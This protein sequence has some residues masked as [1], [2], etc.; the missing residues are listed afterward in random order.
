MI[1][2][3]YKMGIMA[4][5]MV[6]ACSFMYCFHVFLGA[7]S[8]VS[9]VFYVPIVLACIWWKRKGLIVAVA[10]SAFLTISHI[11]LRPDVATADDYFRAAMF[12][13]IGFIVAALSEHIAKDQDLLRAANQQLTASEQQLRASNQQLQASEQQLRAANQ[14]LDASNQQLRASEEEL[15]KVNH[16][17]EDRVKEL[18]CL[19]GL[20]QLI[21]RPGT[22]VEEILQ[23]LAELIPTAWEYSEIT[24]ARIILENRRFETANFRKTAWLQSAHIKVHGKKAGTIEVCYLQERPPMD[25]GPFLKEERELLDLLAKRLG[26]TVERIRDEEE[27][28]AAHQQ[29]IASE[30]QLK[31][32]N[33]QL[34]ANEQQLQAANQQLQAT[35][36]QLKAANQQLEADIAER[37]RMETAL[38]E[39]EQLFRLIVE[40]AFDGINICEFDPDTNKRR[41]VSCNDH[42]VKMSG[43]TREQLVNAENLN[44]LVVQHPSKAAMTTPGDWI[45]DGTSS[46]GMTSWKR[47]DGKE[48]IYEWS[49]ISVKKG[50]KFQIIG[51][52]RDI[53][54]RKKT[55]ERLRDYRRRLRELASELV[56]AE[57]HLRRRI[58]RDLHDDVGQELLSVKMRLAELRK[59]RASA[60]R[61]AA[62]EGILKSV[63]RTIQNTRSLLFDLSPPVLY[64]LG[65]EPAVEWLTEKLQA[66]HGI[67]TVFEDDGQAKPLTDD[68]RIGLFR[69]LRELLVNIVKHAQAKNVKVSARRDGPNIRVEVQDDGVGFDVEKTQVPGD[70][71]NGFG[72]FDI[73]ERLHHFDG[74]F[75]IESKPGQG[76]RVTLLAPLK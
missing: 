57:E 19:Y 30:Q 6:A 64:E 25:E 29:L 27:L 1:A 41:L 21:E 35:E 43:Y 46:T 20:S 36:Q 12:L 62:L 73:R 3:K 9:H 39:S 16:D 13:I 47:P 68:L 17:L 59:G 53:T 28:K 40:T 54:E 75:Q 4:I 18:H 10:S 56:L 55:E 49:A 44:D 34:R 65:F 23:G 50:D 15:R 22:T 33:Q 14:Q 67:A 72:L 37:K 71:S 48:N 74:S 69:A 52:D 2:Q 45:V 8:V 58:A 11:V 66:D 26:H 7:G 70:L 76:T 31:A 61:T 5:L 24:A 51:V 60:K 32:S 63:D 38:R 42:Y